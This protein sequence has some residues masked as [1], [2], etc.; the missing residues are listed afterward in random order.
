MPLFQAT[1]IETDPPSEASALFS[2]NF[3]AYSHHLPI[4]ACNTELFLQYRAGIPILK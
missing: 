4:Q 2:F 3:I 1:L